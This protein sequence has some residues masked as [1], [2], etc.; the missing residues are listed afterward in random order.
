[1]RKPV[2]NLRI[3]PSLPHWLIPSA[4]LRINIIYLWRHR[5]LPDLLDPR[6]FSELVQWRKIHDR[7]PL[8]PIMADKIAVKQ[9]VDQILG[10]GWTIPTY[11]SGR[12]LPAQPSWPYP[13]ILKA[14]HGCNQ[15]IICRDQSD[16]QKARKRAAKWLR[17]PY[18]LWLDEWAYRDIPRNYIVEPYLG[19]ASAVP[20]DYKIYVFAGA[21]AFV[22]VHL[23]R[24]SNHRWI[25][26][27]RQ[28]NQLSMMGDSDLPPAPKNLDKILDGAEKITADFDFARIDFYEIDGEPKF[29]EVTFYPGSGLDPFDPPDLDSTIGALWLAGLGSRPESKYLN[30]QW[31]PK[32]A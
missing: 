23:N 21:A 31:Q 7:N 5:R 30:S 15:N 4:I 3:L 17:A 25:L 29:G 1:M 27:D 8:M 12:H 24:Y 9:Q 28:W 14:S 13:F 32:T 2:V 18:G 20:I 10:S 26:F 11:W 6:R 19:T 22:Q 16:W